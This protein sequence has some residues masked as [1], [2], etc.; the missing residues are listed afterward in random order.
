VFELDKFEIF[1]NNKAQLKDTSKYNHDGIDDYMTHSTLAV[2]NF[3]N[4]KK[5]YVKDLVVSEIPASND[6]L[7]MNNEGE[8]YFIEFKNG[9]IDKH[10]EYAIR[11]KIFDSLLL[12]TDIIGKGVGFTRKNMNYILVYN[13]RKNLSDEKEEGMQI[14]PSREKISRYFIEH[15]AKKNYIRF[16]LERFEKLYFKCVYTY[17]QE[18]FETKFVSKYSF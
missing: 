4:V 9:Y 8:Y 3:D 1:L 15:K 5:T 12:F 14:S 7:F 11:L 6:A 17:T 16:N 10:K 18:I 2:V 13:E